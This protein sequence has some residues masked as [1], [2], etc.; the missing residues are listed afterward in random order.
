VRAIDTPRQPLKVVVDRHGELPDNAR[1]LADGEV[2][3]V[4]ASTPRT[5]WPATVRT[6]TLPDRDGRIDLAAMM[7]A[8]AAEH[9]NE[10]HVEAGARLNGALLA[11]GLVD[12]LLVYFAPCLMGDGARGMFALPAPLERLTDRTPL[13]IVGVDP[14]GTDWRILARVER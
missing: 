10:I 12:E 14:V 11:A 1:L 4:T 2:I 9:I 3:V 7:S 8:L 13:R 6:L 5:V